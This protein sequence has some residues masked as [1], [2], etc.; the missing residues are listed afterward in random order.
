MTPIELHDPSGR[1]LSITEREEIAVLNGHVSAREIAR[2]LGRSPSTISRELKRNAASDSQ[3]RARLAQAH[4]ERR[5]RRPKVSKLASGGAL[6]DYVQSKL[7]G[8]QRWSPEQIACRIKMDF[9][10]DDGMRISHEAMASA[11]A[12]MLFP[13]PGAALLDE[14]Q[15]RQIAD[16]RAVEVG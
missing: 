3:Y 14:A 15:R 16:H 10:Q 4:A 13:A 8:A 9:P 11:M 7:G 6:R 12:R 5:L 2:R 1:Y